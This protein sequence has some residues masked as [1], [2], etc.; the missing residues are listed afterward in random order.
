MTTLKVWIILIIALFLVCTYVGM[1][2]HWLAYLERKG[3]ALEQENKWFVTEVYR[4]KMEISECTKE[5]INF[6]KDNNY[7]RGKVHGKAIKKKSNRAT[8]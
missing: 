6:I 7:L 8:P 5:K 2:H 3:T 4:L 1:R